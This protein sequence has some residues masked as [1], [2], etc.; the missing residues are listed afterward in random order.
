MMPVAEPTA[1]LRPSS[2]F[3]RFAAVGLCNTAID[4]GLFL[5][6]HEP[7]GLVV[8][9][10]CSTSAGMTF[11]FVVNGRY[12]FRTRRF[13]P[14]QGVLFVVTTGTIMWLVQPGLVRGFLWLLESGGAPYALLVAK[15]A[16]LGTC[17]LLTF[18]AY[19]YVVWPER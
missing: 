17:V 16:A 12:T 14:R 1:R 2:S 6:L 4:V 18:S 9:N 11:S 7:L 5:L 19:R 10:L 13:T 8:A 15:L 3:L